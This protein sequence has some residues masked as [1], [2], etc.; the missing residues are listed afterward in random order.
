MRRGSAQPMDV[1]VEPS[2]A[3]RAEPRIDMRMKTTLIAFAIA[4]ACP[5]G[6]QNLIVSDT[7][8]YFQ[9]AMEERHAACK[10]DAFYILTKHFSDIESLEITASNFWQSVVPLLENYSFP[11]SVIKSA[12]KTVETEVLCIVHT[13]ENTIVEVSFQFEPGLANSRSQ[14]RPTSMFTSQ[15]NTQITGAN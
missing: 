9:Q 13:P 3:E 8:E 11:N 15:R 2:S 7:T 1:P 4:I 12:E 10:Q 14:G 6:A 5:A